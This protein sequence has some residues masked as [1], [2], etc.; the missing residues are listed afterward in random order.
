MLFNQMINFSVMVY[1]HLSAK[2][3]FF[4]AKCLLIGLQ[5]TKLY[6]HTVDPRKI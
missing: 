2:T 1:V 3:S 5:D 6:L 4:K